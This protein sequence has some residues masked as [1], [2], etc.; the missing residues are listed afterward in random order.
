MTP[1]PPSDS[2]SKIPT[3]PAPPPALTLPSVPP[4]P[5]LRP[6]SKE[7]PRT[8][9]GQHPA[10]TA[11]RGKLVSIQDGQGAA[12]DDLA[13]KIAEAT[14]TLKT[15]PPP[16]LPLEDLAFEELTPTSH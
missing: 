9:S 14:E 15:P 13:A 5:S 1:P 7:T 12:L 10:V 6:H 11:Y 3:L 16:P 2:E 8:K 4:R